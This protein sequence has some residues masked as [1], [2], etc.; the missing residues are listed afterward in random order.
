MEQ[1]G[2]EGQPDGDSYNFVIALC[3]LDRRIGAALKHMQG[4]YERGF[5][6]SKTTYNELL[7]GCARVHRTRVAVAIMKELKV[8]HNLKNWVHPRVLSSK[9]TLA[10]KIAAIWYGLNSPWI[11]C[12]YLSLTISP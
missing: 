5:V 12:H 1:A 8:N 11:S 4:M 9:I 2:P 6:P 10:D 7:I 3:A